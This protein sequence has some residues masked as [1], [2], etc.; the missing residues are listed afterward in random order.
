[1]QGWALGGLQGRRSHVSSK[2]EVGPRREVS[3][4]LCSQHQSCGLMLFQ[5]HSSFQ[6]C[7]EIVYWPLGLC[8]SG[9]QQAPCQVHPG[10]FQQGSPVHS[11]VVKSTDRGVRLPGVPC[12]LCYLLAEQPQVSFFSSLILS[13]LICKMGIQWYLLHKLF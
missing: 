7:L 1:M 8:V 9:T 4:T 10:I 12:W 5:S 11:T 2:A 13:F 3:P 6:P